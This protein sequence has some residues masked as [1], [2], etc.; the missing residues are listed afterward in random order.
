MIRLEHVTRLFFRG[1][2]NEVRALDDVDLAVEPGEFVSIIGS[3]GAGKSTLLKAIAGEVRVH[4]GRIVVDDVDVTR[5]PEHVRA[6][7]VARIAQDP[8]ASTAAGMSVEENLA[9]AAKRASARGLGTAVTRERRIEFHKV[10]MELELGLENR[11]PVRVGQLSGGQRQALALVMATLGRPQVLLLDEHTAALDPKTARQVME[12]T[13]RVVTNRALT[14]LMVTHNME[15]AIQWG[16]RL[17][18]MSAGR[19][20]LDIPAAEKRRLT[21]PRLIELFHRRAGETFALDRSLLV[22][23]PT[24]EA[25]ATTAV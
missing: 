12:I 15:H 23:E 20:V 9:M 14:T 16:T 10:L 3:N 6:R 8:M 4:S 22:E 17:I 24:A 2:V 7:H 11:L 1:T 19:I 13:N 18:M 5:T 25:L 21:I